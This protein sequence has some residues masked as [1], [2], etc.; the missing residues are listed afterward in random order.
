MEVNVRACTIRSLLL[1][2]A[3]SFATAQPLNTQTSKFA[4]KDGDCVVFY[5][6]SI[7]AQRLYTSDVE[8]FVLTRFPEWNVTFIHSGV[9]GDKVSGGIAGPIDLRLQRDVLAYH[10]GV[11]TIML[12]MN[13]GYV[14]P[15][16]SAIFETY[17]QGYRHL[18]ETL[19]S[20]LPAARITLIKPSPFDEVT[21][22]VETVGSYNGVLQKFGQFVEEIAIERHAQEADL[23]TP[24]VEAL[25]KAK[26]L[27]PA[28]AISLI[29]DR[30]HPGAG[31]HWVM[32]EALL[33]SW[34]ASPLVSSVT[35]DAVIPIVTDTVNAQ[36]TEVHR[37]KSTLSWVE[38]D[39]ALPLPLPSKNSDPFVDLALRA[40]DLV[41]SLDQ[42]MLRIT[43][44][45]PGSYRLSIDR[46]SVGTF[47]SQQ[48]ASG[49]NL[50]LL[51][52]PMEEQARLV[53][54]D[55]DRKNDIDET[56]FGLIAKPM[57]AI[58]QAAADR[59]LTLRALAVQQQHYDARP[60]QRRYLLESDRVGVE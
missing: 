25:T 44:L 7:T 26:A 17:T 13:D 54:Y 27:D 18:V 47:S 56:R 37:I 40:S 57:D 29:P 10:P 22:E 31:I 39:R 11:V 49:I 41:D 48:L 35:L 21:R 14:R 36:V 24:V 60:V 1:A 2:I 51:E 30:V 45:E 19:Q 50:A 3:C 59:L 33:K 32:A 9:G 16:D 46:K 53:A 52:T 43:R 28:L 42:Q 58:S 8:E 23:N 12:G 20:K 5:G 6:D 15:Y 38:T 55:T 34:G 4:L